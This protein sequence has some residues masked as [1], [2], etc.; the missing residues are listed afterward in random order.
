[1]KFLVAMDESSFARAA[2][3]KALELA[4]PCKAEVVVLSVVPNLGVVEEMPDKLV[5][6][7]KRE[8]EAVLE[9]AYDQAI[10]AGVMAETRLASGVSPADTILEA[11]NSVGADVIF[12]GHRG[13][14]NL[15][16][17]LI[18]S[19]AHALVTYAPCS[20]MVVK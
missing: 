20:V 17:F 13:S 11:A 12:I 19:V 5:Q 6:R 2:L 4:A 10:K 16:R 3:D 14:T 8:T 15:E 9:K 7:L 18:G 1:M